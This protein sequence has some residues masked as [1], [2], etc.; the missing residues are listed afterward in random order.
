MRFL[1]FI[2]DEDIEKFEKEYISKSFLIFLTRYLEVKLLGQDEVSSLSRILHQ[3]RLINISLQLQ[4]RPIYI[5][6]MH[7]EYYE[8]QEHAW[9]DGEFK[10]IFRR[11][12]TFQFVEM[13]GELIKYQYMDISEVNDLLE[14][15]KLSFRYKSTSKSSSGLLAKFL[16]TS[17]I[18]E[19]LKDEGNESYHE[20]VFVLFNRMDAAFKA[21]DFSLVLSQAASVFELVAKD[22]IDDTKYDGKTFHSLLKKYKEVSGLPEAAVDYMNKVYIE[23]GRTPL[24]AHGSRLDVPKMNE[25]DAL[26]L[27]EITKAFVRI[28]YKSLE[29]TKVELLM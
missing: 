28:E 8:A 23:R 15:G 4:E 11:L 6:E 18:E 25:K 20:N 21:K 22:V 24:A 14:K 17:E 16:K 5:L 27:I 2:R 19:L 29:S 10:L 9:H 7:D 26:T 1:L 3:N 13:L 12:D